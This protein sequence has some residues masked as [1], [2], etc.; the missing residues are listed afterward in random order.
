M[1]IKIKDP[2]FF[3]LAG[4]VLILLYIPALNGLPIWDDLSFWFN[5]PVIVHEYAFFDIWKRFAW[6]FSV[7]LQK[8]LWQF[9]GEN[10]WF[11]HLF[12]LALHFLNA[13]L[14]YLIAG[15]LNLPLRRWLFIFFL[16][17]PVNVI[18]V[19]WMIQL[20]TILCMLFALISFYFILR[21]Q[22]N[23]KWMIWAWLA[24]LVSI[25]SK[26]ASLPMPLIF[27]AFLFQRGWRKD[28]LWLI[29]IFA[30]AIFGGYR[31]L[32]SPV[33]VGAVQKLQG[34]A[35][36]I[37]AETGSEVVK[38]TSAKPETAPAPAAA[39]I[40]PSTPQAKPTPPGLV[41]KTI[42]RLFNVLKT[43]RYYFWQTI[44]PLR[45]QP[46]KGFNYDRPGGLEIVQIVFLILIMILAGRSHLLFA[47]ISG[48][49]MILPFLGLVPA[50]YMNLTWVSDQH[51][52]LAIPFFIYFWL[53]L[54][55]RLKYTWK[56]FFP[57]PFIILYF[58]LI[59]QSTSYYKNEVAFF[60]ASHEADLLNVPIAYNLAII[61][62]QR[63]DLNLALNI[64]S[65]MMSLAEISP[66]VRHN[67]YFPHMFVLNSRLQSI[68][69]K[70]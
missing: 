16:F 55:E 57:I 68:E 9:A 61:Y 6:P 12:N 51:M 41:Q 7:S 4:L 5:D 63:G 70:K 3:G 1:N 40:H 34:P 48:F 67:K 66:E 52:Y 54:L 25:F 2:L 38:K 15:R 64:T 45:N 17:H 36:I 20:K 62:L 32:Q 59:F 24:F 35:Q 19:A 47:M 42:T 21:A 37:D 22:E 33:T 39:Q 60:E 30:M 14:L 29:P 65:T 26:S 18:T 53:T 56:K 23:K 58:A 28:L 43:V 13:W 8:L 49:I 46:V 44:L 27:T 50:P 31:V 69:F 11:Y 10:F